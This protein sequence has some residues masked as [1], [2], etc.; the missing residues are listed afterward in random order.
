[1][2]PIDQANDFL[3]RWANPDAPVSIGDAAEII[4]GLKADYEEM[5]TALENEK[6][7]VQRCNA[8]IGEGQRI[9]GD[10]RRHIEMLEAGVDRGPAPES[11]KTLR[12]EVAIQ[13]MR[14]FI[15]RNG[16]MA[17]SDTA[18]KSYGMA[19]AMME[20]REK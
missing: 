6:A 20:A 3:M 8:E 17:F 12:D 15:R 19:D 7:E 9:H 1:M 13:A 4:R 16:F 14:E 11:P 18:H 5:E 10:L 2:K